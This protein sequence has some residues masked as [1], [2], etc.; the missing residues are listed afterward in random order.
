MQF[1]SADEGSIPVFIDNA[2]IAF[3]AEPYI[4]RGI[5]MVPIR[6][7]AEGLGATV[8][9]ANRTVSFS[10]GGKTVRLFVGSNDAVVD[11]QS[12]TMSATPVIRNNR[13]Y[14][15]LRFVSENLGVTVNYEHRE[16]YIWTKPPITQHS[17]NA[18]NGNTM[19]ELDAAIYWVEGFEIYEQDKATGEKRKLVLNI[20]ESENT[21]GG[22]AL[23][24]GQL[25]V[26]SICAGDG[27]LYCASNSQVLTVDPVSGNA[28]LLADFAGITYDRWITATIQIYG[29]SIY[30]LCEPYGVSSKVLR[31]NL[32]NG[33]V[34]Q[35]GS[36]ILSFCVGGGYVYMAVV[37]R[38]YEA[39]VT[40]EST[41]SIVKM[42]LSG[43]RIDTVYS[44]KGKYVLD[45]AVFDGSVYFLEFDY[46]SYEGTSIKRMNLDG[47]GLETLFT[48][49]NL[50]TY[51]IDGGNL[52]YSIEENT[53]QSTP[54][55]I[56]R[57]DLE[58]R[59]QTKLSDELTDRLT[60]INGRVY[61]PGPQGVE[62]IE[63]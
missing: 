14:V 40:D 44:V 45:M 60:I 39:Q 19:A 15:P 35:I 28:S 33:T 63:L 24:E 23:V 31:L 27:R 13:T 29:N 37:D 34:E 48:D 41:V 53:S 8:N 10:R 47:S 36:M 6:A 2:R 42:T 43:K 22:V 21:N 56:Y 5:T 38:Y 1:A 59:E 18:M 20:V 54:G 61:F 55:G 4:E 50:I 9:Y 51:N 52:Y 57:M 7:V 58:T 11:G 12:V 32:N 17:P 62:S 25:R 46:Y 26:T 3:D 16:I 30:V 49:S